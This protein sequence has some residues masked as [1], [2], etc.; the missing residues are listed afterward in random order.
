MVNSY[1]AFLDEK[2]ASRVHPMVHAKK[3]PLEYVLAGYEGE[4]V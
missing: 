3:I 1:G 2:Q 4:S